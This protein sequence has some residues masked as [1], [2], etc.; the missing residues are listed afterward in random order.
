MDGSQGALD[1]ARYDTTDLAVE[2]PAAEPAGQD[3]EWC[4]VRVDGETRRIRFHDYAEIYTIPGLYEHLFY[5]RLECCSPRTVVSLLEHELR[6]EAVDP[7]GLRA[8]DLGAGNGMVGEE[9]AEIGVGTIVGVDLLEEAAA[10]AERDRPEVYDAYFAL[11]MTAPSPREHAALREHRFDCLACV[12]ALGFGDIPPQVFTAAFDLLAP[13]AWIAF[14]IKEDFLTHGD[15]TGFSEL[16][17]ELASSGA[18]ELRAQK[19]YR[20]RLSTSGEPLTYVAMVAT[21]AAV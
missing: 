20:H 1:G 10:A 17:A 13:G 21:K 15:G 8:L 9:L 5:E 7:S 4:R 11:D 6:E 18:L 16:I 14:N 19:A 12:A 3:H 2:F